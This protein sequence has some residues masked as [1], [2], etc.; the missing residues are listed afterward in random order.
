MKNAVLSLAVL[1]TTAQAQQRPPQ[2]QTPLSAEAVKDGVYLVKGGSGANAGIV[3]GGKQALVIDAKMSEESAKAMLAEVGKLAQEPLKYLVLT[4]SDGDHVNGLVGFPKGL[5][6][7]AHTNARKDMEEAFKDPRA[8]ALVPYLPNETTKGGRTLNIGGVEVKLLHFGP[9]HTSGDLVV[10]IPKQKVAFIG[11]LAFVGR[12]PLIHRQKGGTSLGLVQTLKK[13]LALDAD[14]FLAGHTQPLSKAELQ[15]LLAS[16]EE[17]QAKV[18]A[19]VQGGGSLEDVKKAFGVV[20]AQGQGPQ[21]RPGFIEIVYQ[22][23]TGKQ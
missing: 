22:D 19:L 20:D 9:A 14:T 17:K 2:P 16:I 1:L 5:S 15:T 11:D 23:V 4:H 7:V 6:I 10:F 8:S 13:I 18:K 12:D 21:R 3:I